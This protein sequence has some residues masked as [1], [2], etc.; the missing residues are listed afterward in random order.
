[1]STTDMST[2]AEE[3][4]SMEQLES[5]V[6]E[7]GNSLQELLVYLDELRESGVTNMYGA[8][9]Y[10]RDDYGLTRRLASDVLGYWMRTFSIRHSTTTEAE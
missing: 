5:A 2:G 6:D 7:T 4:G 3:A 10:L 9:T 8:G 1:M